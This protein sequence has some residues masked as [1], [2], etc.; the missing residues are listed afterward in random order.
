MYTYKTFIHDFDIHTRK[1]WTS[2]RLGK[3]KYWLKA[4]FQTAGFLP[5]PPPRRAFTLNSLLASPFSI[6]CHCIVKKNIYFIIM[7][8]P[9]KENMK[10]KR[11][12]PAKFPNLCNLK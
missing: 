3:S 7:G 4:P 11:K 5:T 9:E 1:R 2:E 6:N 12:L 8:L 10:T